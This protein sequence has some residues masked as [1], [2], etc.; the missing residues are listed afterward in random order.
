MYVCYLIK[1]LHVCLFVPPSI[2][3]EY[4]YYYYYFKEQNNQSWQQQSSPVLGLE[5]EQN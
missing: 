5:L 1:C 4:Y 2:N 3:K